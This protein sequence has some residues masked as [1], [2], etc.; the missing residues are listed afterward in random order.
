MN[1]SILSVP[2]FLAGSSP[3]IILPGILPHAV[4]FC[5]TPWEGSFKIPISPAICSSCFLVFP[6]VDFLWFEP[7]FKFTL[8]FTSFLS[9][10]VQLQNSVS[11]LWLDQLMQPQLFFVLV[12][13]PL[14]SL[15]F[16]FLKK[17]SV[18]PAKY[19]NLSLYL[20]CFHF[21]YPSYL[22]KLKKDV[23][24]NMAENVA[25]VSVAFRI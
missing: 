15:N 25:Q 24:V 4:M 23:M 6:G 18:S 3:F 16:I 14:I 12:T 22:R 2:Y 20:L 5:A 21:F 10:I 19:G 1:Y 9:L 7:V 13:I 17:L 8:F 11:L